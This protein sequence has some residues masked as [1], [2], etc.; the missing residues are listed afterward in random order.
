MEL[1]FLSEWSYLAAY[2]E[3][4]PPVDWR[5]TCA[6]GANPLPCMGDRKVCEFSRLIDLSLFSKR[7]AS[8]IRAIQ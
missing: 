5:T 4:W 6:P 3:I 7:A 8:F 2:G 1:K